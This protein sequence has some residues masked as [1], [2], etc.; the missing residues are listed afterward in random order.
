MDIS[1]SFWIDH[2]ALVTR[3]EYVA[4]PVG[5]LL[6]KAASPRLGNITDIANIRK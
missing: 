1:L 6:P 5:H 2:I 3:E 4:G